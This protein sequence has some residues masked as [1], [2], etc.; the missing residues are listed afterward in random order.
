M[1]INE[2]SRCDK[3]MFHSLGDVISNDT[4]VHHITNPLYQLHAG[5]SSSKQYIFID[6]SGHNE[7]EIYAI[8]M[9]DHSVQ[10]KLIRAAKE[11]V[12]YDVEH[13]GDNFYINTNEGAKNFRIVLV[14]IHNFQND[15][16]KNNYIPEESTKYL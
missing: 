6:I 3:L 7:N 2:S 4:L 12:F 8:E 15:L 5:K 16:W 14:N 11:G 10:P 1:P 9:R 13:N